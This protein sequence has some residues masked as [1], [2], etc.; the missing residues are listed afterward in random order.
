VLSSS[1]AAGA[2]EASR[3]W[4]VSELGSNEA[5]KGSRVVQVNFV[6]GLCA[7]AAASIITH[8]VDVVYVRCAQLREKL[9]DV[10]LRGL[11]NSGL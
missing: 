1:T 6:C 5:T 4:L 8:P 11:G 10:D 9:A 3:L 2:L 7:G